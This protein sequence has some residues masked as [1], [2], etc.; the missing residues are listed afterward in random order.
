MFFPLQN[1]MD[2][3]CTSYERISEGSSSSNLSGTSPKKLNLDLEFTLGQPLWDHFFWFILKSLP[4][5]K[6][7]GWEEWESGTA[8]LRKSE[9]KETQ[10]NTKEK[11]KRKKKSS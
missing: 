3:K 2:P 10:T 7:F 5:W 11:K 6:S 1:E 9:E 8:G 4:I